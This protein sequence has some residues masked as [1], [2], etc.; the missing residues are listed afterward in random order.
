MITLSPPIWHQRASWYPG[1]VASGTDIH[2]TVQRVVLCPAGGAAGQGQS[3]RL[4]VERL[5]QEP[6][7][8]ALS[9]R[10]VAADRWRLPAA[11]T[12]LLDAPSRRVRVRH[13]TP[14]LSLTPARS[15]C[16][17]EHVIPCV[18]RSTLG[19]Y[20]VCTIFCD[21]LFCVHM[22][23]KVFVIDVW[24]EECASN[25]LRTAV[26]VCLRT[27]TCSSNNKVVIN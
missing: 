16:T 19:K 24:C 21:V 3:A 4:H 18:F 14:A 27:C 22:S 7:A 15:L 5:Q 26:C 1:L 9:G 17:C 6:G 11:P 2:C 12:R 23:V 8:D 10:G 25:V 13:L 20:A